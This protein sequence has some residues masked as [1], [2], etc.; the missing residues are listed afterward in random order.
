MSSHELPPGP[1]ARARRRARRRRE[2]RRFPRY[3]VSAVVLVLLTVA[4]RA[5]LHAIGL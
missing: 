2:L 5:L 3:F 1:E 4:A